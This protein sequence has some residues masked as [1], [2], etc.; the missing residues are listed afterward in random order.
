MAFH[1]KEKRRSVPLEYKHYYIEVSGNSL[2][3]TYVNLVLALNQIY[4]SNCLASKKQRQKRDIQTIGGQTSGSE[5]GFVPFACVLYFI[6]ELDS[7]RLP[8]GFVI[9]CYTIH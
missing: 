4:G 9:L 3:K 5:L 1:L 7:S 8:S 6:W 2:T